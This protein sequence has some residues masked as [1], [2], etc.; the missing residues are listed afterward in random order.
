MSREK[1][2]IDGDPA[3]SSYAELI[4]FCAK[5][6][7]KFSLAIQ[8]PRQFSALCHEFLDTLN[9]NLIEVRKQT[10]WPGTKLTR[11]QASIHWY[12]VNGSLIERIKKATTSLYAWSAP[13]LPED[14]A[15]YCLDECALLGTSSHERFAFV[16]LDDNDYGA[17]RKEVPDVH[18]IRRLS[19]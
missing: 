13:D 17:F 2:W 14:P 10:E 18:L 16:N 9:D 19:S 15:F 8:R 3:G 5:R 6:C 11:S 12:R 1:Y 4:E 7:P